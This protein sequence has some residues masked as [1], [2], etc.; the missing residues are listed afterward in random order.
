MV[1]AG[2]GNGGWAVELEGVT[3]AYGRNVAIQDVTLRVAR[4]EFVGV[5]GPNGSGKTTLLRTVLGLVRP[6]QGEVRVFGVPAQ[7]LGPLRHRLGYVPQITAIDTGFPVHV[8]DVVMMGRYGEIGLLHRPSAADRQATWRALERV[9]M[10]DLADRQIGQL[11]GGQR[12]RVFVARALAVEPELLLLDE[13]ATGVDPAAKGSLY[14]LLN[15]L[16]EGGMTILMASHDVAVVSQVVDQVACLNRRLVA[17]G[18]PQEVLSAETLEGCYG[19][20]AMFL[21]HGQFPHVVVEAHLQGRRP[22]GAPRP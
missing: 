11:S 3:V 2:A 1:A 18:R 16:H 21:G 4:Q 9:G 17:H 19:C 7:A 10:Q 22:A 14:E 12:Q 6:V 15:H 20:G 13:P 8:F 5:V